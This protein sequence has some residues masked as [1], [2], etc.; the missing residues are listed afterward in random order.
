[1][2][3]G[4]DSRLNDRSHHVVSDLSEMPDTGRRCILEDCTTG[5]QEG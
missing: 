2:A 3:G 4:L 1:M 5:L